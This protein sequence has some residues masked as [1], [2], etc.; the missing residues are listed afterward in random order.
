[1]GPNTLDLQ[2]FVDR[3]ISRSLLTN[4][5]K[6]AVLGLH[7][8]SAQVQSNRD[9]VKL[10]EQTDCAC[11]I[12]AGYVG[13]FDQNSNGERQITALHIPG[14]MADLHS[15]VQPEATSALQALSTATIIRIPHSQFRATAAAYPAVAEALWRD[16]MV[17]ASILAQ[18]VVNLGRR[19]A[20][21]RI[22]H[23]LCEM[24]V[25]LGV[26]PAKGEIMFPFP[27]TQTQLGDVTGLTAVHVNRMIQSL[28]RE[29]L[30]D[31]RH[32]ATI[33]D[34]D[35]LVRAGDFDADYL[36]TN[37]KPHKRLASVSLQMETRQ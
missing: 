26:A 24:A 8:H 34:W 33:Y 20:R 5:E 32:N 21:A 15:V 30:A 22:A 6:N 35:A 12:V 18:W 25:R 11:L 16:C 19:D 14:D 3:L 28:R 13:R 4:E 17:D 9:F 27:V 1:M 31:I 10:G 23:V 2:R 29:G 7:G 37:V 36:Q